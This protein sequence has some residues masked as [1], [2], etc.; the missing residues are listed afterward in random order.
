MKPPDKEIKTAKR[1]TIHPSDQKNMLQE[2]DTN[3]RKRSI[4]KWRLS[5]QKNAGNS[6][7]RNT[8]D[9]RIGKSVSSNN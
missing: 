4:N 1:K 9:L 2:I 6:E 7:F 5:L 3:Q 8:L